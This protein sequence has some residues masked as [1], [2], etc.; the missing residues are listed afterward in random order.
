MAVTQNPIIG[1]AKGSMGNTVFSTWK[2]KNVIRLKP[3]EVT[4]SSTPPQVENREKLAFTAKLAGAA[5]EVIQLTFAGEAINKTVQN[6]TVQK[7][8]P[9]TFYQPTSEQ[10]VVL[11]RDPFLTNGK[12]SKE[13][14]EIDSI[15]KLGNE[16][17]V[18][19]LR[20]F[21]TEEIANLRVFVATMNSAFGVLSV[22]EITP[23]TLLAY[24]FSIPLE[25]VPSFAMM[26]AYSKVSKDSY[27]TDRRAVPA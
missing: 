27:Q 25:V 15:S 13:G 4:P 16:L 20:A 3:L 22:N 24:K 10:K 17:T 14:Q 19:V 5:R 7:N 21:S 18:N 12:L 9:I 1:R 8:L 6:V 26:I 11:Q 2:G 23:S